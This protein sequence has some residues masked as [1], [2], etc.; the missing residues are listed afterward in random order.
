MA[1]KVLVVDDDTETR[2]VLGLQLR[3]QGWAVREAANA[4]EALAV[5]GR[6]AVDAIVLDLRMPGV[7]GFTMARRLRSQ[8]YDRPI[9]LFSAYHGPEIDN[10]AG[11]LGLQ[12][13]L[14]PDTATLI[15]V[16][17]RL[18]ASAP[19]GERGEVRRRP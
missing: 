16:L 1:Q 14:K 10:E 9:V 5:L 8:G 17:G 11:E 12:L 2:L 7:W 6:E 18:L 19:T 15:E 4:D 3:A 13:I